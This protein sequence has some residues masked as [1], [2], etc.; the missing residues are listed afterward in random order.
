MTPK[1]TVDILCPLNLPNLNLSHT[2]LGE[3]KKNDIQR[4]INLAWIFSPE[5]SWWQLGK[6]QMYEEV[7][8]VCNCFQTSTK[9]C[10]CEQRKC[11]IMGGGVSRNL[12]GKVR[13]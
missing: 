6:N 4:F 8:S 3:D 7:R 9:Q 11:Q 12:S 10:L 2:V 13:D 1:G 5:I